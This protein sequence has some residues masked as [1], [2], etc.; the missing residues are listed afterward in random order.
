MES[1]LLQR[2]ERIGRAARRRL[3]TYGLCAVLAG[4]VASFLTVVA[5]DWLLGLPPILR[6]F[7]AVLFVTGFVL[8]AW[9]WIVLPLRTRF[10]AAH[11]ANRLERHFGEFNDG[12]SSSVYFLQH[13]DAASP[14]MVN[15]LLA[16]TE[17]S[18]ERTPLETALS[19]RPLVTAGA[20]LAGAGAVFLILLLSS[21][22]W[23]ATGVARY[24]RPFGETEW[25]RRVALAALSGHE[26]VALGESVTLRMRVERG[27][28]EG[29]RGLVR[30]REP[31]GEV[32][33]LALQREG[34][35]YSATID[36]VTE[37]LRYW[38]EAG[39][40]TTARYPLSVEVFRRP[41]VVEALATIVPPPYAQGRPSRTV[42]LRDGPA[43]ATLGG[44]VTVALRTSKPV[45]ADD[46][47]SG[48]RL[49]TGERVRLT[50]IDDDPQALTARMAVTQDVRFHVELMDHD[51]FENRGASA[52]AILAVPDAAPIVT[53]L[54]PSAV[55]EVTPR[56]QLRLLCRVE[57]DFG[58]REVYLQVERQSDGNVYTFPLA[59]SPPTSAQE[60]GVEAL[61]EYVWS[62]GP[63][64]L[65]PGEVLT[66]VVE[67]ADNH[68]SEA[69]GSQIGRSA[70]LRLRI[71]GEAEF[72]VRIR[73]EIARLEAQVRQVVLDQS[74]VLDRTTELLRS[75]DTEPL[76][77]AERDRAAQ[78][79]A[80]QARL[81]RHLRETAARFDALQRRIRVN[82]GEE[83]ENYRQVAALGESLMQT[84]AGPMSATTAALAAA[85]E[86]SDGA[87]QRGALDEAARP[88]T[89][90]LDRLR[91]A[92]R[93]MA[94][95]GDF[96]G[97]VAKTRDLLDR[98]NDLR[99]QTDALGR[100]T[101]GK[102]PESLN[103]S[104]SAA[105][106][107]TQRQQEQLTSD[108]DQLTR[109]MEQLRDRA[110]DKDAAGAEAIDAAL[111]SARA[112]DIAKR[113]R[114]A[115]DAIGQNRT[116]AAAVDQQA[117]ADAIRR[118]IQALK[119]REDRELALLKKQ[120]ERAEEQVAELL[121]TQQAVRKATADAQ[122][123]KAAEAVVADLA[124]QQRALRRNT[125]FVGEEL[126]VE[127][128]T[129]VAAR[130]VREAVAPMSDAERQLDASAA[131]QA[132]PEQDRAI[133]LL[134]DALAELQ[135]AAQ[136]IA[137]QQLRRTL[138]QIREE[139][140]SL[141]AS[142]ERVNEG[143]G[144]LQ[145]AIVARG[146]VSR[147]EAREASR[148]AR[149]QGA[150]R[151]HLAEI[152]PDLQKVPVY[153]WALTRVAGWMESVQ[154]RLDARRM[155]DELGQTGRRITRELEQ[156]IQAIVDTEAL[157]LDTEF[158]EA[159]QGG[160]G[161]GSSQ[162]SK[163]IP[164]MAELLVLKA[165]QRDI[166]ERTRRLD[167]ALN[168]EQADEAQLRELKTLGEDQAQ[169]RTLTERVT[170]RVRRPG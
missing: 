15:R 129:A 38:F 123:A 156:L 137:D 26:R 61:V 84:A 24:V 132:L 114:G 63:L 73:D 103:E 164:T 136:A 140:E 157:P 126:A 69:S 33:T 4:G 36:A 60:E 3:I 139:L 1:N 11:V 58:I 45:L 121:E 28:Y 49:D 168:A 25:P 47:Q 117:A 112:Q 6:L 148:L 111:R 10:S 35:E 163:P 96:Q 161:E 160:G 72:E 27:G 32:M 167:A 83:D 77:E 144:A 22:N 59:D 44:A 13:E 147:V 19:P 133:V 143:V 50:P 55:L 165:M 105:L 124:D 21:A 48:L 128:K 90:A 115:A 149:E 79:A 98:Q 51:G 85:A 109:H 57:D 151:T 66:W 16:G 131:A 40:G 39:D 68:V 113:L 54:E 70:P 82:G 64:S 134:S 14:H 43:R 17:Q 150:A 75:D 159:E 152:A 93:A 153:D 5:L 141:H 87:A 158:A 9:Y 169:V 65:V 108:F 99:H 155:D 20:L 162:G 34:D 107:R 46:E 120:V 101:L 97:L 12:L 88:E 29:L 145:D 138:A 125:R 119:Q 53:M 30:L 122:Q 94:Q 95:W 166:N 130:W 67:A 100:A 86:R 81:V 80:Q 135:A 8:A 127:E 31:G 56:A 118:M 62:L 104:E 91:A 41:A 23:V 78:L 89:E 92:L 170:E 106:Q 76:S 71:I 52:Y 142:Q 7:V 116:A 154:T 102:T 110:R 37:D 2:L 18:L 146:S 42:D 74:L